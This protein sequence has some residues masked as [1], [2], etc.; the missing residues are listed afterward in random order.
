MMKTTL[1][2][3]LCAALVISTPTF[4]ADIFNNFGPTFPANTSFSDLGLIL[5]GEDV[6]KI[7]NVDQASSFTTDGNSYVVTG[8]DVG[9]GVTPQ[10]GGLVDLILAEDN[11][12][13]P[14]AALETLHGNAGP[15]K[16]VLSL[17]AAGTLLSP[18]TTYWVIVDA[19]GT[20]EGGWNFNNTG[21]LG[22]TAGRSAPTGTDN[23]GAWN[24]RPADQETFALRVTGRV[25]RGV[26]DSGSTF[27]LA[28]ISLA[29]LCFASRFV[30][31]AA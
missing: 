28:G 9:I 27:A 1:L 11:G 10:G 16:Q 26:P 29:G 4:A 13:E 23:Y 2:K 30:R 8:I 20:L 15:G 24:V 25:P 7:A 19:L 22:A 12:G 3:S 14:G 18:N 5:E 17:A 21:D 6:G 31:K